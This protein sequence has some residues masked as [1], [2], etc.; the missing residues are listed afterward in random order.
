MLLP[1]ES[2][3]TT[4]EQVLMSDGKRHCG[5]GG[6]SGG[7]P[8]GASGTPGVVIMSLTTRHI[9][10]ESNGPYPGT[11]PHIALVSGKGK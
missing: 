11:C 5:M 6:S 3:G 8:P 10:N 1:T 2:T 9:R 7:R 4:T